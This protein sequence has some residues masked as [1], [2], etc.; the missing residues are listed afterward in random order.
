MRHFDWYTSYK[1][2]KN[3]TNFKFNV[4][5]YTSCLYYFLTIKTESLWFSLCAVRLK[6]ARLKA[7]E[8]ISCKL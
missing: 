6:T 5:C 2:L 8:P 7:L 4:V 3:K 1:L